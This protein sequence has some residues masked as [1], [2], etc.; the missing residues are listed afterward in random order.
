VEYKIALLAPKDDNQ[1]WLLPHKQDVAN[2][3]VDEHFALVKQE[4]YALPSTVVSFLMVWL[5]F[6]FGSYGLYSPRHLTAVML[7][8]LSSAAASGAIF[9]ILEL[10]RGTHGFIRISPES[11]VHAIE[12][13]G[14]TFSAGHGDVAASSPKQLT[15]PYRSFTAGFIAASLPAV[16]SQAID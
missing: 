11:L 8:Q 2:K 9:L 16:R 6:L 4:H 12:I 7:L 14:Q 10:Q 13:I 3:L 15:C 1:W 5:V